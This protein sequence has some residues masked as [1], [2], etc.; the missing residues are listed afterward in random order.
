MVF[1]TNDEKLYDELMLVVKLFYT[2]EEIENANIS[3]KHTI[4][5]SYD[6]ITNTI[7]VTN[8]KCHTFSRIDRTTNKVKSHPYK[9]YKRYSKL[10][11]YKAL[12]NNFQ[13]AIVPFV[14]VISPS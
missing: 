6:A 2:K 5:L 10:I 13:P 4:D 14:A 9:Y 1:K 7:N 12:S 3:I 11:L 8:N